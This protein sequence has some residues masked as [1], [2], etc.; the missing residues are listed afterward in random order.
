MYM[1][2]T[3]MLMHMHTAAH[4]HARTH[5]NT[6]AHT[7]LLRGKA[8]EGLPLLMMPQLHTPVCTAADEEESSGGAP[9]DLVH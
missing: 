2:H 7:H 3:H 1:H 8:E 9:G 5:A 6:H 4:T